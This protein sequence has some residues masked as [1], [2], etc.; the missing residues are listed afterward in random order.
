MPN[1]TAKQ[2]VGVGQE[3]PFKPLTTS[4]RF[5]VLQAKPALSETTRLLVPAAKQTAVLVQATDL[6][7]P[8]PIGGD[9]FDQESPP[10]VVVM[11]VEPAPLFP[12]LPTALQ[13]TD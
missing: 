12:V 7:A 9:L 11:I 4:G 6:N 10:L 13:S 2:S 3:I 5:S 1:P 8:V